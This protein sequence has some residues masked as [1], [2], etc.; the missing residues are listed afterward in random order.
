VMR[1]EMWALWA[2]CAAGLLGRVATTPAAAKIDTIVVLMMENRAFDHMLGFMQRGGPQ[3]DPRVD[4]LDGHECNSKDLAAGGEC[5]VDAR[6]TLCTNATVSGAAPSDPSVVCVTDTAL[7]NCPYDPNHAHGPTTERIFGCQYCDHPGGCAAQPKHSDPLSTNPCVTH[8]STSGTPAMTGFTQSAVWEKRDGHNEMTMWPSEKVPIITTLAKQFANFDRFF[9]SHPGPTYPNRQFVHSGAAHGET[10]DEVPKT[11]FPQKTI[12]RQLEEGGKTWK[13][14][15]E[16]SLAWAIFMDD[17]RRNVSKPSLAEMDSFYTDAASGTLPSYSFIEPRIAAAKNRTADPSFGLANHQHPTASVREG[18]RLMKNVYEALRKG[19]KW[20]ST[21]FVITYD[22]HGGF[23]D[24]VP[25]PQE[26]VP[27]PDGMSTAL[28]FNFTR[29]GIR[30]P[31]IAISPWIEEGTLVHTPPE[32]QKPAPTS[33]WELSSIP[34]T[35][36]KL[37]G[38]GG[39]PLTARTAWAATFE[40]LLSRDTPRTDCPLEL[41]EV[42]PPPATEWARQQQLPIDEHARGVIKMLC[43]MNGGDPEATGGTGV[44]PLGDAAARHCSDLGICLSTT[45][46]CGAGIETNAQFS[47]F[48]ARMWRHWM[49]GH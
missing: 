49:K 44:P 32:S 8:N 6:S 46:G 45:S 39:P 26:G 23:F 7:D 2:A 41:P 27:N 34:A 10:D 40:H 36:A 4:G 22:E 5:T 15:Y 3:G 9:C 29:L 16:D 25:P 24:H 19:P 33:Q 48:R 14:Y 31:T 21:L 37:L 13:M 47:E 17:L 1:G 42:P 28:G 43:D 12:F 18:E 38:L 30:I 35:A 11:G 20:E